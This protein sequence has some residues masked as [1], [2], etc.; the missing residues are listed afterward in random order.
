MKAILRKIRISPDKAN[1]VAG[2]VRGKKVTEALALLKFVPKKAA[3]ILYK[4]VNSAA[5]NAKNNYKQNF[6]DLYI[7][8]IIVTK[9]PTFKRSIPTARGRALPIRKRTC[10]ITVEVGVK[11]VDSKSLRPV[12][13]KPVKHETEP[14]AES[15]AKAK[16]K[17][18]TEKVVKKPEKKAEKKTVKKSK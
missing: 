18:R 11:G 9:G 14:K 10:H 6:D 16:A 7:T 3:K 17:V 2:I 13:D 1:L 12:T 15:K 5:H 8:A 4:V